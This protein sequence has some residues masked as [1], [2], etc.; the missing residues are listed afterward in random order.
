MPRGHQPALAATAPSHFWGIRR[1]GQAELARLRFI[2]RAQ[3]LGFSLKEIAD[4]LRLESDT[5]C[6]G[7]RTLAQERLSD[8]RQRLA[9]M[10]DLEATLARLVE[11]CG[12]TDAKGACPIMTALNARGTHM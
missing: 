12:D 6:T 9:G 8:V 11:A 5:S 10:A 2:R 7:A 4:L 3:R 1:Y